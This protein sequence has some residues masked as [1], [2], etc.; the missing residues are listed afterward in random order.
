M[1]RILAIFNNKL[2]EIKKE[3]RIKRIMRSIDIAMDNAEEQKES[4]NDKISS[5]ADALITDE[6]SNEVIQRLSDQFDALEEQDAIISRLKR[7]KSY[8]EEDI[9]VKEKED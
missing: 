8:L 6:D 9:D 4:I 2:D 5:L 1:K 3:R 7:I